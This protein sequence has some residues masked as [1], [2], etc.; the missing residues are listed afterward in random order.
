MTMEMQKLN[1]LKSNFQTLKDYEKWF[2]ENKVIAM[3]K[4][5]EAYAS[6]INH[7]DEVIKAIKVNGK[8]RM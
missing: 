7:C 1:G 4:A 2:Y 3:S 6:N 5:Q 8:E